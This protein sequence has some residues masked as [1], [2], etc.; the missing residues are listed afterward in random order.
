MEDVSVPV[1]LSIGGDLGQFYTGR[2]QVVGG[3]D[4]GRVI[5]ETGGRIGTI[6]INGNINGDRDNSVADDVL[7]RL[8]GEPM[9]ITTGLD[10][11]Q[12]GDIGLIIVG[13]SV[14]GDELII[15]TS[16]TPG[17]VVGGLLVGQRLGDFGVPGGGDD[18]GFF[19]GDEGVILNLGDGSDIRF[20]DTP[21]IDLR[22]GQNADIPIFTNQTIE[23]V[24]DAGGRVFISVSIE[25]AV[26]VQVGRVVIVPVDGAEGVAIARIELNLQGTGTATGG[27]TL[28]ITSQ[29]NDQDVISIGRIRV[30]ESDIGAQ[31]NISGTAEVDVW[32]IDA[33]NGL[34]LVQNTTPGGDIVSIDTLTLDTLRIVNNERNGNL[35][36]TQV[37]EFGPRLIGPRLGLQLGTNNA[38]FGAI[39]V[40]QLGDDVDDARILDL[41][42]NG[43]IYRPTNDGS[44][45]NGE[46]FAED[47]GF[48]MDDTLNGLLVREGGL[49][50]AEASGAIGDVILQGGDLV[51]VRANSDNVTADG[52]F[53]GIVGTIFSPLNI[54][55]VQVGDGL[56]SS[57][58]GTFTPFAEG[59]IFAQS[60]IRR[61]EA[62]Q[63]DA[64]INGIIIAASSFVD[65]GTAPTNGIDSI[66]VGSNGGDIVDSE[67]YISQLDTWW[68]GELLDGDEVFF[69]DVLR[70][71]TIINGDLFRSEIGTFELQ[72]LRITGGAYDASFVEVLGDV[73]TSISADEF[74]NTTLD[75]GL[76]EFRESVIL[77]GQDLQSL[78]TNNN[79]SF[80]D[81]QL[82]VIGEV[83][84]SIR[85]G[86]VVRSA[87]SVANTL[88]ALNITGDMLASELVAGQ[89]VSMT[90]SNSIRI[91]SIA[92]SGP[93]QNLRVQ[94]E[95]DRSEISVT[96]PDGRIDLLE[97]VNDLDAQITS[98]GRIGTLRSTMGSIDGSIVTLNSN[99]DI[100]LIDAAVDVLSTT[101]IGGNLNQ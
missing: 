33:P 59:G 80:A 12:T 58:T 30:I 9:V 63:Q 74:R 25:T 93:I 35:G 54:D 29:G 70:D 82:S 45:V 11:G 15:D 22:E 28:N 27:V 34:G 16:A 41:D 46:A 77:V 55:L 20:V 96:G 69:K 66:F 88:R 36:R 56:V 48:P 92:I 37:P 24:D 44:V 13:G 60:N 86:D 87:I 49:T 83:V 10:D 18:I 8:T 90:V 99:A 3:G 50:L 52:N 1:V 47:I 39:G 57:E 101:D 51:T 53:D 68:T 64:F 97:V 6:D 31:I 67:I 14:T 26:D 2:S 85:T 73:T 78:T 38:V 19:D 71:I 79:G 61:V 4:T 94:N 7:E 100:N 17:A 5:I 76:L 75:G 23:F 65:N 81:T 40:D 43:E 91:T 95:I 72:S 84:G 42:F 32:R 21:A 62:T 89:L 98:S